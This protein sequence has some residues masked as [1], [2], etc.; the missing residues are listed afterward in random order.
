MKLV[1]KKTNEL[2]GKICAPP[3]K[4]H[5][6][7]AIILA[8]LAAGTST[9]KNPLL[10]EDCLATI[11]ACKAI[12]ADIKF[13]SHSNLQIKGVNGKIQTPKDIIDV[14]NSGTTIRLMT[15]I[16]ALC[17]GKVVLTGDESIRKRP[18]DYL[19][20]SLNDLGANTKSINMN[21][22]PPVL[23]EGQIRGGKTTL[24]GI[25]SQFLS[26][27]LISCPLAKSDTEIKVEILKSK[28][29][30]EMTLEH[31]KRVGINIDFQNFNKFNIAG[32]Q[33]IQSK[34]YTIPGDYSSAAFLLAAANITK[35][36]ISITGLDPN[37]KQGDKEIYKIINRMNNGVKREIDLLN[38]PDL[39]PIV[40]VLG[41]YS[42]GI[43]IIKNVEH[44]RLKE[45][46]RIKSTYSNLKKM[47]ADIQETDDGLIVKKSKLVGNN[48]L[49]GH[50]DHRIVMALAVAALG[51]KGHTTI[52][53]AETISVSFP[54]FVKSMQKINAKIRL[55]NT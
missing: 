23:V 28:P 4:S 11:K 38:N 51:A 47:N 36:K 49:N 39:L 31:L 14:G 54:N 17:N 40:A 46:D 50:K 16:I 35:S 6:H 44:A 7:R 12:G 22:C 21:G 3:S 20:N 5:T 19:L 10:S 8:S 25:S 41:C 42:K 45:S 26:G 55:E 2:N 18:I 27:L 53:E 1:V 37:D 32:N 52:E 24:E 48:K 34:N 9:I 33:K 29:Y 43:T 15:S 13:D 30:I